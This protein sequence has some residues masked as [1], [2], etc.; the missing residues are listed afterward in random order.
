M[1]LRH[2]FKNEKFKQK[3]YVVY[4]QSWGYDSIYSVYETIDGSTRTKMEMT[5]SQYRSFENN[6][7]D[8]GWSKE[9]VSNLT[10]ILD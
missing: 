5:E 7:K 2:I 8:Y 9:E 10:E 6:L 3:E 4:F 1:I